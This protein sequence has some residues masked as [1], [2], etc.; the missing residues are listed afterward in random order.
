[1]Q[2][3]NNSGSDRK[4]MSFYEFDSEIAH[5]SRSGKL[6][7]HLTKKREK[8][9]KRVSTTNSRKFR[10]KYLDSTRDS[11]FQVQSLEKVKILALQHYKF[12]YS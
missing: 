5:N 6:H 4:L 10:E 3:V 9:I 8:F 7:P 1:M 11:F 2:S 12:L